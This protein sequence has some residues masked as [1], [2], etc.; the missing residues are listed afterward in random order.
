MIDNQMYRQA[1]EQ[2]VQALQELYDPKAEGTGHYNTA[3][4]VLKQRIAQ[5]KG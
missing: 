3:I 5:L 2:E 4:S 1:L